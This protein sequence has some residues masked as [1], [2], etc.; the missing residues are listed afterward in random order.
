L[1]ELEREDFTRLKMVKKKK[2]EQLKL[3]EKVKLQRARAALAAQRGDDDTPGNG[4][5]ANETTEGRDEGGAKLR[6]KN[7]KITEY[8]SKRRDS[9]PGKKVT[10]PPKSSSSRQPGMDDLEDDNDVVFK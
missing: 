4:S 2:E 7:P 3:E 10:S 8:K 5:S 1:D 6:A 9:M